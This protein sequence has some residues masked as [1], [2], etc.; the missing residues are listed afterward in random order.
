MF[1]VAHVCFPQFTVFSYKKLRHWKTSG[2]KYV[3]MFSFLQFLSSE[4]AASKTS[5]FLL[6]WWNFYIFQDMHSVVPT[7]GLLYMQNST[8]RERMFFIIIAKNINI[9]FCSQLVSSS[10]EIQSFSRTLS[11]AVRLIKNNN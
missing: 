4:K 6:Q 1:S 8:V 9:V 10:L 3:Q 7:L 11:R 5:Q 2:I